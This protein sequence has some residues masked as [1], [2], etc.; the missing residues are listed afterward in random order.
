MSKIIRIIKSL[1]GPNICPKIIKEKPKPINIENLKHTL[2]VEINNK[3][4]RKQTS[5]PKEFNWF[6]FFISL[7][8]LLFI[9]VGIFYET[10]NIIIRIISSITCIIFS[11]LMGSF[12]LLIPYEEIILNREEGT[13]TFHRKTRK[14][15]ITIPFNLG[16]AFIMPIDSGNNMSFSLRFGYKNNLW[17][18]GEL[19]T[20]D[21]EEFWNFVV[22]YMDKNRPLPPGTAFDPY[23]KEDYKRRRGEGFPPPIYDSYI[24]TPEDSKRQQIERELIGK[25]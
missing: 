17:K 6:T 21:M 7:L 23:R 18:G 12:S 15:D 4:C 3:I 20:I 13:I 8:S 19:A 2:F 5:P 11:I 1:S 24:E 16:E 9:V 25:W 10:N 14:R 22:W